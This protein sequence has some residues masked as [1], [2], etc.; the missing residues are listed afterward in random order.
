[1]IASLKRGDASAAAA[2]GEPPALF[3]AMSSRPCAA[4][5]RST[6]DVDLVG[7]AHV[8]RLVVRARTAGGARPPADH[9]GR[10]RLGQPVG[11]G[12]ADALGPT[13]DEGHLPAQVDDDGHRR[14][15]YQT[16]GRR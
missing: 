4:T 1:M 15:V 12:R 10:A 6:S 2:V 9:D 13:G 3:T 11:D 5:T 14:K 8:A 16:G 7:V